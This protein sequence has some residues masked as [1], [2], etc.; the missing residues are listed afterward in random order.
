M[1]T[2]PDIARL[3]ETHT[4]IGVDSELSHALLENGQRLTL[5]DGET[6][7]AAGIPYQR[8]IFILLDGTIVLHRKHAQLLALHS[9]EFVGLSN[10]LDKAP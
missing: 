10:Y 2:H 8:Q 5:K 7:F 6:L 4:F 1:A 3:A 9:G